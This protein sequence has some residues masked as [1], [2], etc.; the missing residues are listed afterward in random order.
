LL[1]TAAAA[2]MDTECEHACG[3]ACSGLCGYHKQTGSALNKV[4]SL[5]FWIAL[6]AVLLGT[7]AFVLV[8]VGRFEESS[9]AV[10]LLLASL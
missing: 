7:T 8:M 5:V 9:D 2:N 4:A 3:I 6:W 1:P 10:S